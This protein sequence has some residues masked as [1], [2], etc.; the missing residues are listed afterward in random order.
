MGAMKGHFME[1]VVCAGDGFGASALSR[2]EFAIGGGCFISGLLAAS[3]G[4][5]QDRPLLR[6]AL[7]SDPHVDD[8]GSP[9]IGFLKSAFAFAAEREVDGVLIAG[10]VANNGRDSELKLVADAWFS[11]FPGGKNASGR[12]VKIYACYGNRD[13]RDSSITKPE[14]KAAEAAISIFSHP[15]AS[16]ERCFGEP[17]GDDFCMK[18]ICGY[19]VVIAHWRHEQKVD[20]F[21]EKLRGKI[22]RDETFFYVQH[23]HLQDTV[24]F[25]RVSADNGASTR[26]LSAYP[27][28]IALSGHSHRSISDEHALW[29]GK[30]TSI[31]GGC[32]FGAT[33]DG[34]GPLQRTNRE[35]SLLSLHRNQ[36]LIE[37]W[38]FMRRER[39]GPDWSL[40]RPFEGNVAAP[41][42]DGSFPVT[43]IRPKSKVPNKGAAVKAKAPCN[44][45]SV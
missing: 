36:V 13:F 43:P 44:V 38:D 8:R 14:E 1:C 26:M 16:W 23:P 29:R 22:R 17:I 20:A 11:V 41:W 33:R 5:P 30:F 4:M 6:L 21:F 28:A 35:L 34:T 45:S 25:H 10:D 24:F 40:A 39:L 27:N 32:V 2:R 15:S 3:A 12:P 31:A 42:G 9:S 7:M 19:K 37:R 18:E